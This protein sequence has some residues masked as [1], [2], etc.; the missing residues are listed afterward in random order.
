MSR[1]SARVLLALVL[2]VVAALAV[3]GGPLAGALER[4]LL[5]LHGL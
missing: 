4:W 1:W 2:A 5:A 3:F